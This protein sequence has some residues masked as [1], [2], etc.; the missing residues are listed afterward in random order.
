MSQVG[1]ASPAGEFFTTVKVVRMDEFS[2]IDEMLCLLA[3]D[4]MDK[5]VRREE[6]E[7][8]LDGIVV[9]EKGRRAVGLMTV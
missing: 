9:A 5:D 2:A 1:L 8:L 3:R 6:A 4:V 7:Q